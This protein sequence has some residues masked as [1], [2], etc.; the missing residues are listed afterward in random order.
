MGSG[1]SSDTAK[2]ILSI[3]QAAIPIALQAMS[4]SVGREVICCGDRKKMA[5][6][7]GA[8][9]QDLTA[10][11]TQAENKNLIFFYD[12]FKYEFNDD[13]SF[14]PNKTAGSPCFGGKDFAFY[15][16]KNADLSNINQYVM[17]QLTAAT[18]AGY[19]VDDIVA[20][21]SNTVNAVY[22]GPQNVWQKKT[23]TYFATK[24]TGGKGLYMD[25]A[26][27]TYGCQS[28]EGD[29]MVMFSF[30]FTLYDGSSL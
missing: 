4:G 16:A 19:D 12:G 1:S 25:L 22:G 10:I 3:A 6:L 26:L 29:T 17:G 23:T 18:N 14:P 24:A 7:L 21:V 27:Y 8:D 2:V 28:D 9:E 13:K 20:D 15:D 11:A 30:L 5:S